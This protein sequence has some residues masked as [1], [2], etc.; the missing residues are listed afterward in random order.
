MPALAGKTLAAS[1]S[2]FSTAPS[3]RWRSRS[4][5]AEVNLTDGDSTP[6]YVAHFVITELSVQNLEL[7]DTRTRPAGTG[8]AGSTDCANRQI[9]IP[10]RRRSDVLERL[11]PRSGTRWLPAS[12]RHQS[13]PLSSNERPRALGVAE[14]IVLMHPRTYFLRE[15]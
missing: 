5:H 7:R 14:T 15:L 13:S 12:G 9:S 8:V 1:P 2:T 3:G 10:I 11:A 4:A 6:R